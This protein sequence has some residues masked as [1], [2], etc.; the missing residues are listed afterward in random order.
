PQK[1]MYEDL[2]AKLPLKHVFI[3]TLW[4]EIADYPKLLGCADVGVSLHT[5]T[6]GL[7]L[8]MKVLDMFGCEVPVCAVNFDCLDELV[9][10]GYNGMIFSTPTE[11]SNQLFG[12]LKAPRDHRQKLSGD[13]AKFRASLQGMT[14]WR[15]NWKDQA[16]DLI[17]NCCSYQESDSSKPIKEMKQD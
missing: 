14:R 12:L 16:L 11:L 17:M 6:S 3:A 9:K 15:Q 2:I 4:L 7:D 5:S 1:K 13:L 8:P 10:D